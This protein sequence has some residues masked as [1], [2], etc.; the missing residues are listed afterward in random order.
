[1]T[2][3]DLADV[4]ISGGTMCDVGISSRI[5]RKVPTCGAET[6]MA[7]KDLNTEGFPEKS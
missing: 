6:L 4:I 1:M 5:L 2:V 7:I 3:C